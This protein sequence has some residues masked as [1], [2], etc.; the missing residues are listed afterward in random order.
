MTC[1]ILPELLNTLN[2][3]GTYPIEAVSCERVV[4]AS[5]YLTNR[6]YLLHRYSMREIFSLCF[7]YLI[8]FNRF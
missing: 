3:N 7:R 1:L 4:A 2:V 5:N 8:V 6:A